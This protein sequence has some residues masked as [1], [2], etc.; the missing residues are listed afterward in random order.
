MQSRAPWCATQD[1]VGCI[2]VM[3]GAVTVAAEVRNLAATAD[4]PTAAGARA[5]NAIRLR[6][7]ADRAR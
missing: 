5:S 1:R 2:V 6:S 7:G 3:R 4:E